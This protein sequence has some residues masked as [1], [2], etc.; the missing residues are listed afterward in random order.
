MKPLKHLLAVLIGLLAFGAS[1]QQEVMVSQYMFNGLF[2]NP[3]YAGSHGYV[4][5]SMLHRTQWLQVDG[6]PRTS[7]VAID[8]P[9]MSNT[10]GLGFSIVHDQI[11]ISRDLDISGHYAYRLNLGNHG[12]LAFGLRAGVSVYSAR[13][14]DLRYWDANDPLYQTDIVNAPVGKFG[15]GLYWHNATSYI[16]LSVPTIYA[17]DGKLSM[18]A[19]DAVDHYFTQ[20]YYL[21][22]GKVFPLSESFDIKPSTM[23]KYL[24][25]A[26][27]E[28]DVN[29]N[30]L[31]RERVW[32][33]LGYRT[34]DALVG[35]VEYQ[36]N[37]QIRI[38]YAYDMTTSRLRTYTSG[39]HEVM[40]GVDFGRNL[41]KI[42]TPRYF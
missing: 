6:A 24:P 25:S 34:G 30:L 29:C 27:I 12:S 7:M 23:I 21:Q 4:S 13:L 20:H 26:P 5:S 14:S 18:N 16:G 35:M 33:G 19:N 31:Y 28:A 2:L 17:S 9:L 3:A 40:L 10:M 41:V 22:A 15:F 36:V 1:A 8:G 38:G 42:K 11:G 37:P 39:S 32:F